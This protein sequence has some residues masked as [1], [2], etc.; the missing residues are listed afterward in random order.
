M[1]ENTPQQPSLVQGHAQYVKGVAEATVGD[2]TG[3]HA[4]KS[5][6]E[7][8]KAAGISTMKTAGEQRDASQGYGKA[9]EL[10]G[11]LTGCDGMK[12]EGVESSR[13]D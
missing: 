7:Q 4:W 3:S 10:A 1:S 2:I 12:K 6:G 13:K 5:S 8:D 9:E 11:K